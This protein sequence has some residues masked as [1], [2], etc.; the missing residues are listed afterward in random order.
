VEYYSLRPSLEIVHHDVT[1]HEAARCCPNCQAPARDKFCSLC[2]ETLTV[3]SPTAGEFFHEFIG[4]Y[5]ALEGK[6]WRTL[7]LLMTRP[8]Q[9]TTDYL[10]GRR[11]PYIDPLR[12]YLTLSLVMFGLIKLYGVD[13]PQITFDDKSF[14]ASYSH[15]MPGLTRNDGEFPVATLAIKGKSDA[16]DMTVA[17]VLTRLG[18]INQTWTRNAQR[19]MGAPPEQKAEIVNHGFV[20]N[21][22]YMLIG[23]LPLFALYLK[24][25]WR[26]SGRHYGDHLVF[27][28]HVTAFA[29]V[30]ASVMILIPGNLGWL[31]ACVA[32]GTFALI[33]PWDYVQLLPVAWIVA[34]V[35]AAMRTVYGGSRRAARAR[36]LALMTVHLLVICSLVVGAEIIAILQ[37]G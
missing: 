32:Q 25:I 22:P 36:S 33:S 3:H 35:P 21:L 20:A 13:L 9:L 18:S 37:H 12:L 24:V 2:G 27:A 14:G 1:E 28:L 16:G 30:L 17:E 7:R 10:R 11:V 31:I 5:I 29:F 34:Y 23:A 4:H 8:G 19:F 26:R 15:A 6:L